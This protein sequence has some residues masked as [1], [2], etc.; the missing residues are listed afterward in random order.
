MKIEEEATLATAVGE[1]NQKLEK[2]INE[3]NM[4][5]M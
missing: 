5:K 3:H 1:I 2:I 4:S